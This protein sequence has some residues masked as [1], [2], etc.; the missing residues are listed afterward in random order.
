M[1]RLPGA[2]LRIQSLAYAVQM[3]E[4]RF[5]GGNREKGV[6]GQR[7]IDPDVSDPCLP[8]F[9]C[10]FSLLN[11]R[12]NETITCKSEKSTVMVK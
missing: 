2:A 7:L 3:L 12:A 4:E 10:F 6:K 9:P 5:K 11:Q 8:Y 1:Y